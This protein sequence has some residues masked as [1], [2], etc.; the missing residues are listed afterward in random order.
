MQSDV[1]SP[2]TIDQLAPPFMVTPATSPREP[3]FDQRSC[4]QT[5]IM[6]FAFVGLTSIQG[7]TS[8]PM[9]T[10]PLWPAALSAVHPASGLAPD[11]WTSGPSVKLAA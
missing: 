1:F 4:C 7:S 9:Y 11:T 8:L 3:P 2:F 6:L 5:P 10:V